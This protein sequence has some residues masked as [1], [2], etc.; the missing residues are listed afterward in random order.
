M[1]PVE[2]SRKAR[3]AFF[4]STGLKA[5]VSSCTMKPASHAIRAHSSLT[6]L[7]VLAVGQGVF[8]EPSAQRGDGAPSPEEFM[9]N[10]VSDVSPLPSLPLLSFPIFTQPTRTSMR[11]GSETPQPLG[12]ATSSSPAAAD[13]SAPEAERR[14]GPGLETCA[15]PKIGYQ[16]CSLGDGTAAAAAAADFSSSSSSSSSSSRSGGL[17]DSEG[18]QYGWDPYLANYEGVGGEPYVPRPIVSV[19]VRQGDK[20]HEMRLFSFYAF[21]FMANRIRRENPSVRYVWLSTEMQSVVDQSKYT[22]MFGLA[23]TVGISFANLIIASECDFFV[24]VLESNWN[25]MINELK[26]TNG[27]LYNGYVSVNNGEW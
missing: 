18:E 27:R 22:E 25:R 14:T 3:S 17:G 16:G 5:A 26:N 9:R 19:H 24:G 1:V 4:S 23:R 7:C 15:W 2:R 11:T 21:M 12:A 8:E 10:G 20:T 6:S 13:S